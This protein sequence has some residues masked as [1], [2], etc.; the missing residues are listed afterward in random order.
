MIDIG[1]KDI[2][3]TPPPLISEQSQR[4]EAV[5]TLS[6]LE[7]TVRVEKDMVPSGSFFETAK[8]IVYGKILIIRYR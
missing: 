2:R 8:R 1:R 5:E 3:H 4:T 7:E 6:A